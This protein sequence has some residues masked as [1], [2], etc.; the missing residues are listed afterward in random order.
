[1]FG[2]LVRPGVSFGMPRWRRVQ[3]FGADCDSVYVV[4]NEFGHVKIGY[5]RDPVSNLQSLQRGSSLKLSLAFMVAT[6]RA[7]EVEQ[8]AHD[9][10]DSSR[11]I[12]EWFHVDKEMAIAAVFGAASRLGI[13][14]GTEDIRRP[15]GSRWVSLFFD[16]KYALGA[17]T[18]GRVAFFICGLVIIFGCMAAISR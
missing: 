15:R 3:T 5:S 4:E 17:G 14:L 16:L 11:G 2:G 13:T 6:P 12:G 9:I 18:Y 8:A 10:L 1:M 7:Y